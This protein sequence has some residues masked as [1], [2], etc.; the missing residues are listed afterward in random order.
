MSNTKYGAYV[1]IR[2]E[3]RATNEVFRKLSDTQHVKEAHSIA[4][5]YD[6]LLKIEAS[7]QNELF[8]MVCDKVRSYE[9]IT[10]SETWPIYE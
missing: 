6:I 3:P 10:D 7:N 1:A 9:G 8:K 4:G 2:T 5:R